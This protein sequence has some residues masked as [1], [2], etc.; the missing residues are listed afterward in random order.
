[1]RGDDLVPLLVAGS[2]GPGVGFRQGVVR[3][4]NQETAE[5]AV[6]VGGTV[7]S[8][9]PILNTN[10][11]MQLAPGDVVGVLTSGASW[12]ILGRVTIPG[13]P[14]AASALKFVS[15]R[16]VASVNNAQ[17][18]LTVP[19]PTYRDLVGGG[20]GPS[21]TVN[22]SDSGKALVFFGVE[23]SWG[24]PIPDGMGAYASVEVSGATNI[25]ASAAWGVGHD[26]YPVN[27]A[28]TFTASKFHVFT[29]L[30]PGQH[31][32]TMKYRVYI[33]S[34]SSTPS[35]AFREREIA[36]FAL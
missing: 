10:E 24:A 7:M 19:T 3:E 26:V 31:T 8:N 5:N 13:T 22:I 25:A 6:E 18:A 2:G 1:M 16:I 11:A 23:T 9:L 12:F 20:A 17:G 28:E 29:G 33:V 34:G 4:W 15:N 21:V 14:Q 32:F 36:V 27:E 35:I 30:N